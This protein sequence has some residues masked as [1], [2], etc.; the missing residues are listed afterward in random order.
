VD[1]SFFIRALAKAGTH[2]EH[3]KPI[4]NVRDVMPTVVLHHKTRRKHLWHI[5]ER[6]QF[7]STQPE[8][9]GPLQRVKQFAQHELKALVDYYG[10][11]LAAESQHEEIFDDAPLVWNVGD[12]HEPWPSNDPHV[13]EAV[14][15]IE[16]LLKDEQTP[17]SALHEA[18]KLL[19]APGVVYLRSQTIHAMLHHLSILERPSELAMY[20]FLAVLDDMKSAHIHIAHSEWTTAIHLVGRFLGKVSTAEV[21]SALRVW[22]DMEKRAGLRSGTVTMNVLFDVAVKGGKYT[23]AESF[24]K[25]MEA[26]KLKLHRHFRVSI[27]YYYGVQRNGDAVRRTYFEMIEAGDIIDTVVMNAVIAALFRA[28]EPSAAEHVFE[29]MKKLDAGKTTPL[30]SGQGFNIR[31][32]RGRRA[33]G[34]HLTHEARALTKSGDVDKRLE[35]QEYAPIAPNSRTYS[36]LIRHYACVVGDLDRVS[37]LI[38]D[39]GYDGIPMEGSIFIVMFYGFNTFGGSRYSSWTRDQLEQTWSEYLKAVDQELDRTWISK[40]AVVRALK[41]FKKCADGERTLKA[42]EEVR[43]VWK[44]SRVDEEVVLNVLEILVPQKGFLE[45]GV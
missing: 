40:I 31:T 4:Y 34:L 42:W 9:R 18:Y 20:R 3:T 6:R 35:L 33:L 1:D 19:P 30:P 13:N 15:R 36:L 39:M 26:R 5:H 16:E 12:D 14:L 38:R 10:I 17:H 11:D 7:M 43:R 41:A 27:I 32:W 2:V 24:L 22:R 21:Q 44:P 37:N 29:R 28:G 45:G 8:G 23:L 25:E